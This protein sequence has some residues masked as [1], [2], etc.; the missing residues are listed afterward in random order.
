M[1]MDLGSLHP[2]E[3]SPLDSLQ[4]IL[5]PSIGQLHKQREVWGPHPETLLRRIREKIRN[6][7]LAQ[8]TSLDEFSVN[9]LF[10]IAEL[11]AVL[12]LSAVRSVAFKDI[13]RPSF[14]YAAAVAP[15]L[16]TYGKTSRLLKQLLKWLERAREQLTKDGRIKEK[17]DGTLVTTVESAPW[18]QRWRDMWSAAS[19]SSPPTEAEASRFASVAEKLVPKPPTYDVGSRVSHPRDGEGIIRTV[20]SDGSFMVGFRE[21]GTFHCERKE[22]VLLED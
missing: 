10:E 14:D 16:R 5:V 21:S 18:F 12:G 7:L 8:M 3:I 4:E 22:L 19:F 11:R 13:I 6:D 2:D 20:L 1:Q 15:A 9:S 17:T